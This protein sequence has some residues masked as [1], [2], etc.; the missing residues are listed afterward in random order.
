MSEEIKLVLPIPPSVNCLFAGKARRYKSDTYKDWLYRA[1][2]MFIPQ[3]HMYIEW[4]EWL[5]VDYVYYMP[6]YC[7]NGAKKKID[8][9][10]YEKALSDMLENNLRGFKDQNIQSGK[11]TKIQSEEWLVEITIKEI[12]ELKEGFNY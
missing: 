10:N 7:K 2:R 8:V 3:R 1:E 6:I 12:P 5:Y 9:F 4:D 11:V